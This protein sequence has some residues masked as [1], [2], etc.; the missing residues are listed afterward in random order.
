MAPLLKYDNSFFF[1]IINI[2][3]YPGL[4][5]FVLLSFSVKEHT[6]KQ[7]KFKEKKSN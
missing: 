1:I 7:I 6:S 4:C 5:V 3:L 2:F